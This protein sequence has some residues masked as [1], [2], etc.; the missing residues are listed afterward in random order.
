MP[1]V[2]VTVFPA[3]SLV[4]LTMPSVRFLVTV[5][6]LVPSVTVTFL[7]SAFWLTVEDLP[8]TTA[9]SSMEKVPSLLRII[10][11]VTFFWEPSGFALSPRYWL[12][13]FAP[14]VDFPVEST[15]PSLVLTVI[16]LPSL[17]K[18]DSALYTT[19]LTVSLTSDVTL[20]PLMVV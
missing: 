7:S 14:T 9:L 15:I 17:L 10:F 4:S 16:E 3:P 11:L 6:V 8:S 20:P 5:R 19:P 13:S 2:R 1:W 12:I 18:M